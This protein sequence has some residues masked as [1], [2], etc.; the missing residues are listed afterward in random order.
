MRNQKWIGVESERLKKDAQ[1]GV[2]NSI[3]MI[4][5]DKEINWVVMIYAYKPNQGIEP[6][7]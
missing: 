2:F 5:N 7:Y 3:S 1:Q 6:I 4:I